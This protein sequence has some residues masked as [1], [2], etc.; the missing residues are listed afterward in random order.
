[1]RCLLLISLVLAGCVNLDIELTRP[2]PQVAAAKTGED[3]AHA[4]VLPFLIG[5]LSVEQAMQQ[6]GHYE[7]EV[8][9]T[10]KFISTPI[11][12]LRQTTLTQF[13]TVFYTEVCV[14][15]TGE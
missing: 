11:T 1:M 7:G 12:K 8:G 2:D 6:A 9:Y 15:A 13:G 10:K 4:I 14:R 5:S 3:C